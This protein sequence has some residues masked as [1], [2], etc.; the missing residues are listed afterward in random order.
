MEKEN[1]H[2]YYLEELSD[3]KVDSHYS[4]VTGWPVKDLNNRVIGKVDN[5]LV[6]KELEKVVY[7][8]VEVDRSI[9]E[10]NHDPYGRPANIEIREF[11]NKDGENH[12]IIPIGMV[13]IDDDQKFVYTESIDHQTFSETKRVNR[14]TLIDRDYE[15]VVLGSYNREHSDRRTNPQF[16]DDTKII[17]ERESPYRSDRDISVND[18]KSETHDRKIDKNQDDWSAE[19]RALEDERKKLREER[20]KLKEER[21]RLEAERV[22][23]DNYR[24]RSSA[25]EDIDLDDTNDD[26]LYDKNLY[27]NDRAFYDRKEFGNSNY[28]ND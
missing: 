7:L 13:S 16:V 18:H 19:R 9:I 21:E 22:R 5:L 2:L 26:L 27:E 6:N 25:N 4:D 23:Y 17:Q 3:Y 8:D 15:K 20:L 24:E 12:I 11:V 1:K 10:A 28:K 14:G